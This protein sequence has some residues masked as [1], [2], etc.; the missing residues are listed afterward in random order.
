MGNPLEKFYKF[1]FSVLERSGDKPEFIP[2]T[3]DEMVDVATHSVTNFPVVSPSQCNQVIGVDAFITPF[4]EPMRNRQVSMPLTR[5]SEHASI[6]CLYQNLEHSSERNYITNSIVH[7]LTASI[8]SDVSA[9]KVNF[10]W[11]C[12]SW[13]KRTLRVTRWFPIKSK[14]VMIDCRVLYPYIK[15]TLPHNRH[16]VA[17]KIRE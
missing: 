8:V 1:V 11:D 6:D 14:T 16:H 7:R 12:F 10:E 2:V 13:L 5:I 3:V 9:L 4:A 15:V 17:F